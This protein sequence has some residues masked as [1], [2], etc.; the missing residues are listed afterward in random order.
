MWTE[1]ASFLVPDDTWHR[2]QNEYRAVG[3]C[4]DPRTQSQPIAPFAEQNGIAHRSSEAEMPNCQISTVLRAMACVL[5]GALAVSCVA[6]V[7]ALGAV[8]L[9]NGG[10]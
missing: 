3:G 5:A 7:P 2:E 1:I 4:R 6:I 10:P 9:K 8:S